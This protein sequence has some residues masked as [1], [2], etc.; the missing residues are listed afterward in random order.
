ME[1]AAARAIADA[2]A[3][4]ELAADYVIPS[5]FNRTVAPNV[6]AAVAAAAQ[7]SGVARKS[8]QTLQPLP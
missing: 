4:D 7:R 8:A 2:I 3:D 5:V 6:A 1:I